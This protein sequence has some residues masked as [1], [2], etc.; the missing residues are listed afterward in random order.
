MELP[1]GQQLMLNLHLFN[2]RNEPLSGRSGISILRRPRE[3][4]RNLA[5]T[6][7]M[8]PVLFA[9][10]PGERTVVSGGCTF[11]QPAKLFVVGP[12][13]HQLGRHMKIMAVRAGQPDLVL[14]DGPFSFDEQVFYPADVAFAAGDQL[15][16]ECT[17]DN[18][19]DRLV[20]F[21]ESSNDE[22]CLAVAARYPASHETGCPF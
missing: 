18:Q 10:P 16:V 4:V 7:L 17:F 6:T 5:D 13:M 15:R 11:S 21:G 20:G 8:G 12:H 2:V 1:K 3:Q 14:H 22:M 9:L 19:S